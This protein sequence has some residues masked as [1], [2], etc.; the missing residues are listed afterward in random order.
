MATLLI[1]RLKKKLVKKILII[2][3]ILF[4]VSLF[5]VLL[6]I[7]KVGLS[8]YLSESHEVPADLLVIEGWLPDKALEMVNNE[9][10]KG[11]YNL[12]VTAGLQSKE[13]EFCMVAMN[14]YLIFYPDNNVFQSDREDTHRIGVLAK[15]KMD[16]IYNS[17]FNIYVNDSIIAD[18]D[19]T[20]KPAYY[21]TTWKGPLCAIDSIMIQFTNDMVDK[22]GDRNLYIKE[23]SIDSVIIAYQYNSVFDPGSIGGTDRIVNDYLTL[24]Q[25][26][27]N[28]LIAQGIDSS[29]IIAITARETA[30]NRTLASSLAV[31]KWIR[32]G[33]THFKGVNIIS[34]GIHSRRTYLTYRRILGHSLRV[35]IISLPEPDLPGFSD[36]KGLKT[37]G[38]ALELIYYNLILLPFIMGF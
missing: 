23:I 2:A 4:I 14:G 10:Q 33:K 8:E 18:F 25:V 17:H 1:F 34:L 20:D 7:S 29:R 31:R 36:R 26:V 16:G 15:S 6:K 22:N 21:Y 3:I 35:G 5:P 28:K 13:L 27:R 12:I 37:A 24:P 38:E 9:V 32:S 30:F 11:K 19:A